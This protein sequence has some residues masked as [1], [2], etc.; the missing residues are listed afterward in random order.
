MDSI[1]NPKV[2]TIKGKIVGACSLTHITL[3][4]EGRVGALG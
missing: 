3:G 2:K 4:V 1:V